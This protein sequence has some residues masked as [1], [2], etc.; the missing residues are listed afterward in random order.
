MNGGT[1]QVVW[2]H[3][4]EQ[5]LAEQLAW[6]G[7]DGPTASV[8]GR[9]AE[10]DRRLEAAF[11]PMSAVIVLDLYTGFR[12]RGTEHV[13]RCDLRDHRRRPHGTVIVKLT[14][15][16]TDDSLRAERDAWEQ[17]RPPGF[18]GDAVFLSQ[19]AIHDPH[20]LHQL[21]GVVYQDAGRSVTASTPVPLED[22]F[23]S[24]VQYGYPRVESVAA[25]LRTLFDHLQREFH[26]RMRQTEA[27]GAG[28][29]L[30]PDRSG[31]RRRLLDPDRLDLWTRDEQPRT[32][33]QHVNAELPY[34]DAYLDPVY[35]FQTLSKEYAAGGDRAAR[36]AVVPRRGCAH[37]DL[38]GRNVLV[39]S[40][41][42]TVE[43]PTVFD[44]EHMHWDN[45]IGL[46][47]A[48]LE[49]ELKVRAYR[50]LFPVPDDFDHLPPRG[51]VDAVARIE[52]VLS[53]I[54]LSPAP[55]ANLSAGEQR[56]VTLVQTIR[57]LDRRTMAHDPVGW[58]REY[59]LLLAA[60]GMSTVRFETHRP[61]ER[62]AALLSA[63]HSAARFEQLC[64][65]RLT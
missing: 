8:I 52:R 18:F 33:R 51:F 43:N 65:D 44:Y 10:L 32:V 41:G 6:A 4:A 17:T 9:L 59:L 12:P 38:H 29:P 57:L 55:E 14:T 7:R 37:G 42:D 39:V 62:T 16:N 53:R 60:Y 20:E 61:T 47:A 11:R 54:R 5:R 35:F 26:N 36:F 23:L 22:V 34:P 63:G 15:A 58:E 25:V 24:A 19:T 49:T 45:L 46:D 28:L 31:V 56:L 1:T 13:L 21:V 3:R 64:V 27:M 50:L 48:K 40:R 2:T 30:N